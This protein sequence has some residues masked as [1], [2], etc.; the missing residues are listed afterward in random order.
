MA[1]ASAERP[2]Q[3]KIEKAKEP[4]SGQQSQECQQLGAQR[5]PWDYLTQTTLA[6]KAFAPLGDTFALAATQG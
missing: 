3:A 5:E 2:E 6:T 4:Q 1:T